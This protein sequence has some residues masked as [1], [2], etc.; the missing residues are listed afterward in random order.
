[1]AV[2][3]RKTKKALPTGL[4]DAAKLALR[5]FKAACD[6]QIAR[7]KSIALAILVWGPGSAAKGPVADKRKQIRD[8]L[9]K[10]GHLAL[11]S[12]S[13]SSAGKRLSEK[14]KEFAEA[15]SADLILILVLDQ[16]RLH[17]DTHMS[18]TVTDNLSSICDALR[19][20]LVVHLKRASKTSFSCRM[21]AAPQALRQGSHK[22]RLFKD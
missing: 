10:E 11:F 2:S 17:G 19:T 9:I 20:D 18:I 22:V 14:S 4:T 7:T 6:A 13:L 3:R 8:E 21:S 16:A 5:R 12:E 15:K 1:M